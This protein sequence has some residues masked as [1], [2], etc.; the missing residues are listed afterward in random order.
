MRKIFRSRVAAVTIGALAVVGLG[1]GG[2]TAAAMIDSSDIRDNSIQQ[3]D[4]ARNSVGQSE[5]QDNTVGPRYVT[6]E[7]LNRI[8][9]S[10]PRGPEG[11]QGPQGEPGDTGPQ[12]E[13]GLTGLESDGPYPGATQLQEGANSTTPFVGNA[14]ASL[15]QAWVMCPEGKTAIGGGYSR[16]DEGPVAQKAL[17]IIT[18][19]P[20]QIADGQ[21]VYNPIEG[22]VDGSFVPNA[23]LVEGYNNGAQDLIVRPHVVCAQIAG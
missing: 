16:A 7:L 4:L 19:Q 11:P 3:R 6:D 23:W 20:T 10:G 18:S 2:A 21:I 5:L 22:D 13:P 1:A 14:G 8:N 15:Q 17:Q 12:G 9:Q